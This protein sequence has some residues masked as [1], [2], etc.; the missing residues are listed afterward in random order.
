MN[1]EMAE[2]RKIFDL[3]EGAGFT[4]TYLSAHPSGRFDLA[5]KSSSITNIEDYEKETAAAGDVISLMERNGCRV[6]TYR[7]AGIAAQYAGTMYLEIGPDERN[8]ERQ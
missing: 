5:V 6:L 7:T 4:I 1:T 3:F 2:L 8:L